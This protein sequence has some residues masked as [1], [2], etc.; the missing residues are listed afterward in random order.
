MI[1]TTKHATLCCEAEDSAIL[2]HVSHKLNEHSNQPYARL[3]NFFLQ[4]IELVSSSALVNI[5]PNADASGQNEAEA[6]RS[7]PKQV[8]ESSCFGRL[9]ANRWR[10]RKDG[11]WQSVVDL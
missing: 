9:H 8:A 4:T 6:V 7:V 11:G 3:L 5:T 2:N 1:L 10:E